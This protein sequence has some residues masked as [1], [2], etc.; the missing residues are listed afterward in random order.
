MVRYNKKFGK[1]KIEWTIGEKEKAYG[2]QKDTLRGQT[3]FTDSVRDSHVPFSG[4]RGRQRLAG[5]HLRDRSDCLWYSEAV[6][7]GGTVSWKVDC[8]AAHTGAGGDTFQV[9]TPF[10]DMGEAG[11]WK[12]DAGRFKRVSA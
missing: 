3:G 11:E 1:V 12:G 6:W 9:R 7:G 8:K 5:C 10:C 4:R 2:I